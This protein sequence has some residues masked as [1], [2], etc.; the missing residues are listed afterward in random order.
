MSKPMSRTAGNRSMAVRK[1][2]LTSS[3]VAGSTCAPSD[4]G[5]SSY[6]DP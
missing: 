6:H 4:R 1:V 5:K 3:P 2:P